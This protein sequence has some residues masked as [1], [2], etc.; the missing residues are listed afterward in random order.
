MSA[1]YHKNL[2]IRQAKAQ[3][4]RCKVIAVWLANR[5]ARR[6]EARSVPVETGCCLVSPFKMPGRLWAIPEALPE[7]KVR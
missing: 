3:R 1:F 7:R 5:D 6:W 4:I 2:G